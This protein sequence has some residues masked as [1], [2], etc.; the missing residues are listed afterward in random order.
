MAER[1]NICSQKTNYQRNGKEGS[2]LRKEE[3]E[4]SRRER[5][6]RSEK[7]KRK[8]RE[9]G[10]EAPQKQQ[11]GKIIMT[12]KETSMRRRF[13]NDGEGQRGSAMEEWTSAD[14]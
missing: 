2:A 1:Q 12:I 9:R 10:T 7:K 8:K 3:E 4:D 14:G 11:R 5:K 6:T 13:L